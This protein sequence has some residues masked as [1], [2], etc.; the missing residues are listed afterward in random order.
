MADLLGTAISGLTASQR[1]LAVVGNNITNV[2]TPGYSRQSAELVSRIPSPHGSGFV[3]NGVEVSTVRRIYDQFL[4]NQVTNRTSSFEQ[5]DTLY[6]L[7]ARVD[8]SLAGE[9]SSLSPT[10]Q[11]FFNAVQDVS[12]NPTSIPSREVMVSEASTLASR[13]QSLN[14]EFD[15]LRDLVNTQMEVFTSEVN[16]IAGSIAELNQ[17]IAIARASASGQPPNDLLDQRDRQ[18]N[19]LAELV[20]VNRVEAGDGSTNIFIGSGQALVLGTEAATLSTTRGSFDP[21]Q[22]EILF[23]SRTTSTPIGSQLN[24]GQLGGL[25]DFRRNVLNSAQDG[26][27]RIAIGMADTFNVQHQLGDDLNGNPGGLFF[28]AINATSPAV[29]ANVNNNAASG[30]VAVSINDSGQLK[31]SEYRLNY[32]GANFSLLRLSD[33]TVVDSGFGTAGLPRTVAGEGITLDLSGT[34]AAGDSFLIRPVR[35][36]ARDM[37]VAL[38][39]GAEFAAAA[40]GNASGDNSNA[41]AMAGLQTQKLLGNG[42]ETYQ[43]SYGKVLADV[44]VKTRE[45]KV[46]S[47]AQQVLLDNAIE[48]NSAVSGVNLDEEAADLIKYQQAYQA[49]AQLVKVADTLF[50]TLLNVASR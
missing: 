20:S 11:A 6:N 22:R 40:S 14:R 45:A 7:A 48:A 43:S 34:I 15:S 33:N 23:T 26:L 32:D 27:G 38:A 39:S 9:S 8:N 3:G 10:I 12:N 42:S 5:M 30:T 2:N 1:N 25:M 28:A 46:N 13:F 50:Q 4:G 41:L 49:A 47:E 31:A 19:R 21:A 18:I 37:N 24:G 16:S 44:G 29:F 36:G 17:D 35:Y